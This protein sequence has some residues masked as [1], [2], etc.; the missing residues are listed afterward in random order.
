MPLPSSDA[1]TIRLAFF[2]IVFLTVGLLASPMSGVARAKDSI[3]V[4]YC[5]D[6]VPFH[7]KDAAGQPAG[8]IID[9][10]KL[11]SKKTGVGVEFV[12]AP[13]TETLDMVRDGRVDAHAGLFKNDEREQYLDYGVSLTTTDTHIFYHESLPQLVAGAELLPYRVGVIKEDYVEGFLKENIPGIFISAYGDYTS[14]MKEIEEGNL[15]T[16]AADTPAA[17]YYLKEAGLSSR[18]QFRAASPLYSNKWYV[19]VPKGKTETLQQIN[20]G[21]AQISSEERAAISRKWS[22]SGATRDAG[23]IVIAMDRNYPPL[24]FIGRDG[25]PRG[26]LVDI[27]NHWAEKVGVTIDFRPSDWVGTLDALKSG[28]ADIHAGLFESERRSEWMRFGTPVYQVDTLLYF[29]KGVSPK[30]LDKMSGKRV[31]VI[32]GWFQEHY[33]RSQYPSVEVVSVS[34]LDELVLALFRG[35]VDAV[36]CEGLI[37]E[38]ELKNLGLQGALVWYPEVL[39]TKSIYPGVLKENAELLEKI[40]NGFAQFGETILPQLEKRWV[41]NAQSRIYSERETISGIVLTQQERDWID[42]NPVITVA[43]TPDWPPF[44]SR[45]DDGNYVG[46]TADFLRLAAERVGLKIDYRFDTWGVLLEQLKAGELDMAPGVIKTPEREEFLAFLDPFV[47]SNDVIMVLDERDDVKSIDDLN[48]KTVA[49]E[50]GYYSEEY[51]RTNYPDIKRLIVPSTVEA[52]KAVVAGKADAYVGMQ[53]VVSYI[54]DQLFITDLKV[55]AY[56]EDRT[57]KLQAGVVKEKVILKRILEKAYASI[58]SEERNRIVKAHF[59]ADERDSSNKISLTAAERDWIKNNPKVTVAI[60][61]DW[62]PMAQTDSHGIV[63]GVDVDIIRLVGERL[64]LDIE[65]VTDTFKKN[66]EA[67][68]DGKI[69]ALMDVTPKKDR[70]EYLNFTDIYL[71]IPHVVVT[72]KDGPDF[73]EKADFRGKTIVVESGFGTN[74]YIR[75][76]YPELSIINRPDTK[77]CLQT[78][79]E[80]KGDAYFGNR[81]VVRHIIAR[82]LLDNLKIRSRLQGRRSLLAIGVRK[83]KPLLAALFDKGL[84]TISQSEKSELL[85]RFISQN[86]SSSRKLVKLTEEEKQWIAEHP[87][88]RLGIDPAL[89]PLEFFL[90]VT[91][92]GLSAEYLKLLSKDTGLSFAPPPIYNWAQTLES[93]K[94][95]TL[96][97]LSAVPRTPGREDYLAFTHPYTSYPVVVY[98][99]TDDIPVKSMADLEG[100]TVAVVEGYATAELLETYHSGIK[101]RYFPNLSKAIE[102]L[103][104]GRVAGLVDSIVVI[105]DLRQRLSIFNIGPVIKTPYSQEL[106]FG[107]REDWPQLV[108]IIDKWLDTLTPDDHRQLEIAADIAHDIP[109][110][111]EGEQKAVDFMQLV[112]LGAGIILVFGASF[113]LLLFLRRFI[114][115]RAESLYSSHQYKVVGIVVG[116][117]F[118]CLV[119]VATWYAL[120]QVEEK[121]RG[122]VN[123]AL[124]SV[125]LSTH[126]ALAIWERQ[127]RSQLEELAQDPIIRGATSTLLT[128]PREKSDYEVNPVLW[129]L[130]SHLKKMQLSRGFIDYAIISKDMVNL[131]ACN[132]DDIL[133]KNIISIQRPWLLERVYEGNT[134]FIPPIFIEGG[135]ECHEG[136]EVSTFIATAAPI[137]GYDGK[138]SAALVLYFDA[139]KSYQ[140]F[141]GLGRI[142]RT[143]ETYAVDKN[144]RLI[145]RTR[146][147]NALKDLGLVE[148]GKRAFGIPIVDPG[149]NLLEGHSLEKDTTLPLTVSAQGVSLGQTGVNI[150]GYRDY[151]GVRVFGTWLWDEELG[152]GLIS[153]IDEEEALGAYRLVR[154]TVISIIFITI[155]LGSLMTGLSNWIG[156]SAAR[157]LAKAKDELE[158]R[159]EERTAA[160]KR[161]SVAVEQSPSMVVITDTEGTIKYVNPKFTEI[162]GYSESEV[163]GENPRILK[164]GIHPKEFYTDLWN[165]ILG[166]DIWVGDILN[167]KKDGTNFWERTSIAPIFNDDNELTHFVAVKE[168]ITDRKAQEERFQALLDAAPDAMVIVAQSGEITL[169]NIAT[170]ELFEY[171][172]E[173]MIGQKV[174]M[175]IPEAIREDHPGYRRK[176]FARPGDLSLVAGKEFAGQTKTGDLVPVDI[177]LSPIETDEGLQIIASIRDITERKKAEQALAASEERTRLILSSAGE[178]IFGV[179]LDGTV[180]FI[181]DAACMLLGYDE[182]EIMGKQVHPLI[183]HTRPDGSDYPVEECPMRHAFTKGISSRVDDEVLWRKDGKSF[184]VEYSAVPVIRSEEIIG[185]VISFQ[186]ISKRREAEEEVRVARAIAEDALSL[187]TSSIQYAS[188]IQR[189]VLPPEGRMEKYTS[190]NFVVW[191]PRDVVGGDIYWCEPWGRGALIML[192]DCTGHGVP[193]AFMTLISTG[194]LERAL[195][196]VPPGD[197][198]RLMS[199]VHQMVQTQLGQHVQNG[200]DTA[201]DDGLEVGICYIPRNRKT[202]TY[203]GARMP[204]FIDNGDS[205]ETVKGDRKGIGYRGIPIDFTYTNKEVEVREGMRFV[206]TTDGIIDQVG[207]PKRRGFGKKR[208]IALLEALRGTPLE[209]QGDKIYSELLTYQGEEKRRDDVSIIGFRL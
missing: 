101:L 79:S 50:K 100:R 199:R 108:R 153:E 24:S 59:R 160:L 82:Q 173:E 109:E 32:V 56:V 55:A 110:V 106:R 23:T 119:V 202:V 169:V 3:S 127:N 42:N 185:A 68:R 25:S 99:R 111:Q 2:L 84:A 57:T 200:D 11:W 38:E 95:K 172:R 143:G 8:M 152:L 137:M 26:L 166:G 187:V 9:Y 98:Q 62:P 181:N 151:R 156:Q 89:P 179:N 36:L 207:G 147:D 30:S 33:L 112:M 28:E 60:M 93:V 5:I 16:F 134:V 113:V 12:P 70:E 67:V 182:D 69:D 34:D 140:R 41:G 94:N 120:A 18:F 128:L 208:F 103:S 139:L 186:D 183:H 13:W 116:L 114:R 107:V 168:D 46:V 209:S 20:Q 194:A 75:K 65:I 130:R 35:E 163:V 159:V 190:E 91:H 175:L 49:V 121:L 7:F 201:S 191:E 52:L 66:L 37:L 126:E 193:G 27:W 44:E 81:A 204:L 161:T 195:L 85:S 129:N 54:I 6:A 198:A 29:K 162:T 157:S 154:N 146:F 133:D 105:E 48:G 74:G 197:S 118:L 104:E 1:R 115:S 43:C 158:D 145:S 125:L 22:M 144:G 53:A 4:V 102:A 138:I 61:A 189:S 40:D 192:G 150:D 142:G 90:G 167:K 174:E 63:T 132:N 123:E 77:S 86:D 165:T 122:T 76:N 131:A 180:S 164:S 58:T 14:M 97:F 171:S 72:R 188:R 117:M 39:F 10:W 177:S 51:L 206:M 170:E 184:Y 135:A 17:L 31:G 148:D 92:S 203:C 19:A 45:D 80:G 15:K 178:G 196:E 149:G 21:M 71:D 83:D 176:F 155:F 124:E 73:V 96:D 78:L 47:E 87:N 136:N 64:G 141:I 88:I 205:V